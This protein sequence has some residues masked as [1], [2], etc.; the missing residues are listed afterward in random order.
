MSNRPYQCY[1]LLRVNQPG[2]VPSDFLD[3]FFLVCIGLFE[4]I[5]VEG[6]ECFPYLIMISYRGSLLI[7]QLGDAIDVSA[8]RNRPVEEFCIALPFF[9]PLDSRLLPPED[10]FLFSACF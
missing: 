5:L 10:F 3:G 1:I 7:L 4:E 6:G 8:M 9:K 2:Y